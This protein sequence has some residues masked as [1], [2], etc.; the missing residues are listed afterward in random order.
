M[1]CGT[2][3]HHASENPGRPYEVVGVRHDGTEEVVGWTDCADGG[4]I[5]DGVKEWPR[6]AR[7]YVRP[8]PPAGPAPEAHP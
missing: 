5:L 4:Q 2:L 8:A 7:G 6:Y 1:T 3:T